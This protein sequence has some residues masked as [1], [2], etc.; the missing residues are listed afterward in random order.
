M[1]I[2]LERIDIWKGIIV[3]ALLDSVGNKFI[4]C[5]KAEI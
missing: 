4:V 5:K 3:K 2:R 1:K